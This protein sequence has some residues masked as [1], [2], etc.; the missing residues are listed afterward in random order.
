MHPLCAGEACA[1]SAPGLQRP[2]AACPTCPIRARPALTWARRLRTR[3]RLVGLAFSPTHPCSAF[4]QHAL[5]C[6]PLQWP[7]APY[8]LP[9]LTWARRLRAWSKLA[10]LAF[11]RS[12]P[13]S[14]MAMTRYSWSGCTARGAQQKT[15]GICGL[16]LHKSALV[17]TVPRYCAAGV[18]KLR[19]QRAGGKHMGRGSTGAASV[20]ASCPWLGEH[21]RQCLHATTAEAMA[22]AHRRRRHSMSTCDNDRVKAARRLRWQ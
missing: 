22:A 16:R 3:L 12:R 17:G 19:C 5:P 15:I 2:A 9:A 14:R 4:A 8:A 10:R 21:Q 11:S 6:P 18:C 13:Q 1:A 20:G 7:Y